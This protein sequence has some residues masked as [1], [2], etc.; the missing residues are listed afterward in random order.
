MQ[1]D[2]LLVVSDELLKVCP[3]GLYFILIPIIS[4]FNFN[5]KSRIDTYLGTGTRLQIYVKSYFFLDLITVLFE[6][7]KKK[8]YS[9]V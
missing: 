6:M 4:F 9:R 1:I 8:I 3:L 2:L 5:L 7:K